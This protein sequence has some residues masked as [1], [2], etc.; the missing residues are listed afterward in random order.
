MASSSPKI[1]GFVSPVQRNDEAATLLLCR[2]ASRGTM[3]SKIAEAL[4]GVADPPVSRRPCAAARAVVAS[5][6]MSACSTRA[7]GDERH[8]TPARRF[9]DVSGFYR[10]GA[11]GP[12][13]KGG[14]RRLGVNLGW[15]L[16][17]MEPGPCRPRPAPGHHI[18]FLLT[19]LWRSACALGGAPTVG[20]CLTGQAGRRTCQFR[21]GRLDQPCD[22]I[23]AIAAI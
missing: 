6:T 15:N 23:L 18:A 22:A 2:K 1:S 14:Q 11:R 13:S 10:C 4:S 9:R 19:S 7:C 16:A 8:V 12:F 20:K 17:G 3:F 5:R 21:K